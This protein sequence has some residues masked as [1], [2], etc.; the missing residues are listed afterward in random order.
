MAKRTEGSGPETGDHAAAHVYAYRQLRRAFANFVCAQ[1]GTVDLVTG[2][3]VIN[4]MHNTLLRQGFSL[5][6]VRVFA[7]AAIQDLSGMLSQSHRLQP[8]DFLPPTDQEV[9][10]NMLDRMEDRLAA[11]EGQIDPDATL[12]DMG[13]VFTALTA[14]GAPVRQLQVGAAIAHIDV[15]NAYREMRE[16]LGEL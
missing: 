11:D 4:R 2:A 3:P 16:E 12:Q 8:A 1:T 7:A 9:Y 10:F 5:P 13:L 6:Q 14:R 15:Q